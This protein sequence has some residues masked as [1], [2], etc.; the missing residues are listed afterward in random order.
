MPGHVPD[1]LLAWVEASAGVALIADEQGSVLLLNEAGCRVYGWR[2][3]AGRTAHLSEIDAPLWAVWSDAAHPRWRPGH[4]SSWQ[5]WHDA[6]D[7]RR[8]ALDSQLQVLLSGGQRHLMLTAGPLAASPDAEQELKRTLKFVQG[9]IDAFPDFLFEGS[10]DGRYL[11]A[12]THN[13][14]LLAA[15]REF[16]VGRTLDEVLA[17]QSAAIARQAFREADESGISLGRVIYIDTALGRHW[18]ELSVARMSMGEG[19]PPHFITVSRDV[20]A[21]LALQESLEHKERQFRTLVEN[22]PDLIA[23]FDRTARC[24]YANPAFASRAHH[25]SGGTAHTQPRDMLGTLAGQAL[26]ERLAICVNETI[27]QQFEL[28]WIDAAQNPVCCLVTLTPEFDAAREVTSVLLVGRDIGDLR[29]REAAEAASRAKGEFLASMSHE[30]RTPMNAIIGMSYL[31]LQGQL[32]HQQRH[33]IQTVH[34]S[35]ESLL[36]IINDILDFSKI[37]AGKLDIE[38]I[39]F[40]LDEVMDSLAGVLGLKAQEKGLELVFDLSPEVPTRLIGDPSRLSQILLNLGSNAVK[41]T[42][43]GEVV[44]AVE[45]V[46]RA[47]EAVTLRFEVRDTGIG[48]TPQVQRRL[49]QPFSQAEASTSRRFGGTGLGLAICRRLVELMGGEIGVESEPGRGSCFRFTLRMDAPPRTPERADPHGLQ[50]RRILI[51]D[52]NPSARQV[53]AGMARRLGL[54]VDSARDAPQALAAIQRED[55]GQSPY[56]LVLI[57]WKMPQVD[58]VELLQAMLQAAMRH[59]PPAVLMVTGFGEQELRTRLQDCGLNCGAILSKPVHP[60]RL[61]EACSA[62]LGRGIEHVPA[63]PRDESLRAH[64]ARLRGARI[65]LVEDNAVNQELVRE[66]LGRCGVIVSVAEHGQQAVDILA[67]EAFDAVLMD[68]QMPVMDGYEATVALRREKH[69]QELPIIAMTANTMVGDRER[70]LAAGMNDQI[71]KPIKV[72]E[73]F[74]TLAKWIPSPGAGGRSTLAAQQPVLPHGLQGIDVSDW[75]ARGLADVSLHRR[76]LR[77]Y[78]DELERFPAPFEAALA[79]QDIAL[80]RRLAH[81]LKSMSATLGAHGIEPAAAALERACIGGEAPDL[82][83]RTLDELAI[84]VRPVLAGLRV[85]SDGLGPQR[86]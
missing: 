46:E 72:D 75:Q 4:V 30:I 73:M 23:R 82:L 80:L 65:L 39:E 27:A 61:R 5:S 8:V 26:H 64:Q 3:D 40:G 52:D 34:R 85:W 67:R 50:G 81:D 2:R 79:S 37:E 41:F 28:N 66:L 21:R 86:P 31:A 44:V 58:G 25:H 54:Q 29:A 1:L 74:A 22:S 38:H 47:D 33:Y 55:A 59:R 60:V 56:E 45:R 35:A 6:P 51:V 68:C 48:I 53:L 15:S 71:G 19:E 69:L 14:E 83:R 24:I 76:L 12:W 63:P 7:G 78:F 49:F 13:P 16:L 42:Q 70:A 32:D 62:A 9:I 36:A 20:T 11:N 57:D 43:A 10:A 17:P 84:Q 77:M 18:Y